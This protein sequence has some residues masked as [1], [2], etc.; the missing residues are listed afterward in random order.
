MFLSHAI[1]ISWYVSNYRLFRSNYGLI[2]KSLYG[3]ITD[4]AIATDDN[5]N[6]TH[7]NPAANTF[8]HLKD[9]ELG[10]LL[11]QLRND[12]PDG[13]EL[14]LT[15]KNGLERTM[16]HRFAPVRSGDILLGY[17]SLFTD[18]TEIR[19][20]EEELRRLNTTKD[21]LFA[22]L[23]HDL[24]RPALAFRDVGAKINYLL[25]NDERDRLRQLAENLEHEALTLSNLLDNLLD[26]ALQ[27][28][29]MLPHA[30]EPVDV[31]AMT[32]SLASDY[33]ALLSSKEIRIDNDVPAGLLLTAGRNGCPYHAPQLIG[34]RQ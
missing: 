19:D 9:H 33:A 8:F 34:Q 22:I 29:Q 11:T 5:G 12:F 32:T 10:Q 25:R 24:R 26:W 7:R 6:V 1:V 3:S 14:R 20:R 27:Q 23:G 31:R 13:S 4:L 17:T 21:R 15:D 30:P 18:L 28:R 16:R 2:T